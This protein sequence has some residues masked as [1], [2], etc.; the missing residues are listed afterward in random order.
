MT[1]HVDDMNWGESMDAEGAQLLVAL[2]RQPI[3]AALRQLANNPFHP[4]LHSH[5]LK[6]DLS[7][8]C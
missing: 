4:L 6:G 1:E 2:L 5:K 7:L 3:E 8:D